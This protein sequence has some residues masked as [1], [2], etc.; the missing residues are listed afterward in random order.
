MSFMISSK[1]FLITI[2]EGGGASAKISALLV[3]CLSQ[4]RMT[5]SESLALDLRLLIVDLEHSE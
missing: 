2:L 1:C 3:A 4:S 5:R